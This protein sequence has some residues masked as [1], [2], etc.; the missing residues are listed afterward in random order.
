MADKHVEAVRQ[1]LHERAQRGLL[2]Y[3]T[4][5]ERTDLMREQWLQ[6]ALEEALDFAVYLQRCIVDERAR[7]A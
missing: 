7:K 2:K 3:G 1:L 6:H 4:T 5:M